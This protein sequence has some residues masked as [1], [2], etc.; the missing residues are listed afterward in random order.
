MGGILS[1]LKSWFI[2]GD[3]DNAPPGG[4]D[5]SQNESVRG[6]GGSSS[7]ERRPPPNREGV[8]DVPV[9]C[10]KNPYDLPGI[11]PL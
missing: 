5:S 3:S 1:W 11:L 8:F 4:D 6:S 9:F 7:S 10:E 2:S